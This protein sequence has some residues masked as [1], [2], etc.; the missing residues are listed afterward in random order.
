MKKFLTVILAALAL[1]CTLPA[2]AASGDLFIYPVPPDTMLSL[3]PRCDY[4]VLR[5]WDRCNF[6]TAFDKYPEKLNAAFGDWISI[7][8]HASADSV[9]TAI[10][11]LLKRFEK[12][13]PETLA[14][15]TMAENW[16][17]SDT[18]QFSSTEVYLPFVR[19][20]AAH[21]KISKADRARF[22]H[23]K[24][25]IESS[26]T[27]STV[28]DIPFTDASGA[29]GSLAQVK[30]GSILLFVNDPDCLDC[31]MARIR[32]SA[33]PNARELIDRGELAVVSIYPGDTDDEGWEKARAA[34]DPKWVTVA[35]PD[36]DNYFDLRSTPLFLFL[37]RRH[38]VLATD[39]D[40]D[41]LLGAFLE[42]NL[43]TK[44]LNEQR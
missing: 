42:A 20:A 23:Q 11:K 3:Q 44:A 30:A 43:K 2:R 6:G 18:A 28:P 10:D 41:Y 8:P 22:E 1:M 5:F 9:H 36:A 35:M 29:K 19:A 14:L 17:Y 15:A 34:S 31:T 37:N 4:I 12:K 13:G 26:S 27:G 33:D 25:V 16:L 21:K 7:M 38:R 24:S 32:L 39:L 40:I